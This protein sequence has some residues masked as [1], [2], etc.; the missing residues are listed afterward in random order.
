MK[1]IIFKAKN[2]FKNALPMTAAG[3]FFG[4]CAKMTDIYTTNLANVFSRMSVWIF[5]C[6]F[7]CM[8]S[9]TPSKAAANVFCFCSSMLCCYYITAYFTHSRYYLWAAAGWVVFA[10]FT[11]VMAFAC[12]HRAKNDVWAKLI[13][14]GIITAVFA[15]AVL[16]YDKVRPA[17]IVL[18]ILTG[19]AVEKERKSEKEGD[20]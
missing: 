17:D 12:R 2:I 3:A 6:V 16:F 7:I 19:I 13:E 20:G 14:Y 8:K 11:P 15:L 1:K 18:A 4:F 9:K 5:I 10:R